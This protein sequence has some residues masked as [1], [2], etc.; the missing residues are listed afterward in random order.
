VDSSL[1]KDPFSFPHQEKFSAK[2][3]LDGKTYSLPIVVGT[4]D[5][6]AVDISTLRQNTGYITLDAEK[7][8]KRYAERGIRSKYFDGPFFNFSGVVDEVN[9]EKGKVRVLVSIFGRATPIELDFTQV[10]KT[11]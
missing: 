10:E 2:L 4:E 6:H 5:E 7:L 8:G 9:P 3:E 1:R 11:T